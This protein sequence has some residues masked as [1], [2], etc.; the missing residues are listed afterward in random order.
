MASKK[1]EFLQ[2]FAFYEQLW[3]FYSQNRKK[4]RSRYNGL[5]KKFLSYND[6]S[7]NIDA[8]LRKPQFEAL[9]MYVFIKEFMKN[10]HVY[11]M[12][13]K[14]RN[15]E[16]QF[17]DASFYTIHKEGQ[18]TFID[19]GDE[20]NEIVFKQMEKYKESYPN[21]IYALTMGLGKTILMSTCIFYEFLLARKYPKDKRFCHNVLVF[22]PDKTVLESLREIITFDKSKV[23]PPEYVHVLD[24]NIKFH[25]LDG[26]DSALHTGDGSEF[27]I[28]ISNNQ[29]VIVKKKHKEASPA[30]VLFEQDSLLS[31]IYGCDND[32]DMWDNDS[33]IGNQ[34]FEKLC[35]LPQLGIYVDEAHHLFGSKLNKELRA[36]NSSKTTLRNTINMLSERTSIVACYNYTG[37]PY[38]D[39]QVL[40]EVVYAYG[41]RESIRNGYLK[42]ADVK[43][44]DNVKDDDFLRETITT[45]WHRYGN[46]TYE[47]LV[48]KLAIFATDVEDATNRVRPAV[49]KI[50]SDLGIPS[51]TILVNTG[52]SNV[53]KD[54]DIRNFNNLDVMGTEGSK[55]Q[56][57][58][59]VEKGREGW[60]CRSLLGVALSRTPKSK[61]FVL[62]ATMRCLRQ[63]TENQ[64]QATV[65]LS[66]ENY[67]I[68][69]DELKKN[70]HMEIS[71]FGTSS[72]EKKKIYQV[73]V[74]PPQRSIKMKRLWHEYSIVEKEYDAPV[75]FKL[76]SIDYG[77][78]ES[79]IYEKDSLYL[80]VSEKET[81]YSIKEQK[82]FS[83]LTLTAEI[84][85]YMNTPCLVVE[86]ILRES[87]DGFKAIV[88]AVNKHNE[89][90]DDFIIPK[91][92]H[93]LYEVKSIQRSED[94]DMVLL[95]KPKNSD[96]YEYS[97]SED[98]VICNDDDNLTPQQ[99]AKSFHADTYCFDSKP[100]REC[101][102]QY[103]SSDKVKE[104]YFTG[105]FTAA[106]QSD[107]SV[108]YYDPESRRLRTYYPDF[109][110]KMD[111]DTYQLIEVKGDNKIDDEVVIAK[112]EAAEEVAVASGVQ[113]LMYAGSKIMSSNVLDSPDDFGQSELI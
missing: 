56:F 69:D 88:E 106:N 14:W 110:A 76:A 86:K 94:V 27:N 67:D 82:L 12:F 79:K 105:M 75:D 109:L 104:V 74:L 93:T 111:D 35:R 34:R 83:E 30:T 90:M 36:G 42:D 72:R 4:I 10:D 81:V 64:L 92:F 100:E 48:P 33:L 46:K 47:G 55:K 23:V 113:Y 2:D 24:E 51:S 21:Y 40:P 43:G 45:F 97:A 65:F 54:E 59:L 38:V 26:K 8:F 84:S 61:V 73:R 70:Y 16:D 17:S 102:L 32:E 99:K 1:K 31:G 49:E 108:Q 13:D 29:K 77:K 6:I 41:L 96:Y 89:I 22:A 20:Q 62:Q 28:I 60:N 15:H 18:G 50:L 11:K 52:N 107:L 71:D 58:I 3:E 91:I 39:N 101:F 112:K 66:K 95:K 37:T 87:V 68:L 63:L 53:T 5:T 25:F 78:Y 103:I 19:I 7:E 80:N 85:S 44:F 98:L 9:E 57:I